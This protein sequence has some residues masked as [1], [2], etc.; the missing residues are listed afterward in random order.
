MV[1]PKGQ[2]ARFWIVWVGKFC[3][4]RFVDEATARVFVQNTFAAENLQA[5]ETDVLFASVSSTV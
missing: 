3:L 1:R 5:R 4:L 2:C